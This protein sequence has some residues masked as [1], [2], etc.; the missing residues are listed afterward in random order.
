MLC[1]LALWTWSLEP[2]NAAQ[3]Q[4]GLPDWNGWWST[5]TRINDEI[6]QAPPPMRAE[7]LARYQESRREDSN[8]DP[9]RFCR[10]PQFTGFIGGFSEAVEFLFT[11][12]RVTV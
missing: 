12:G 8:S 6:V 1:C 4:V 7:D 10:P 5:T 11:P 9:G 3:A 2:A